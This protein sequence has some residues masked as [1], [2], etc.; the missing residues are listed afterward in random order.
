MN[1]SMKIGILLL[2]AALLS[3]A[4]TGMNNSANKI[5]AVDSQTKVNP[6]PFLQ[7]S[8]IY[9]GR[10]N[11]TEIRFMLVSVRAILLKSMMAP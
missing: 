9:H 10:F 2:T 1:K 11:S 7:T 4:C 3:T 8:C 6:I 5:E